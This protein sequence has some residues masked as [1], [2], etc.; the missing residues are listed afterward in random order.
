M[1]TRKYA[2]GKSVAA[3]PMIDWLDEIIVTA[4]RLDLEEVEAAAR[5]EQLAWMRV[6]GEANGFE[7]CLENLRAGITR[8][9]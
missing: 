1:Q 9:D 5:V 4:G 2:C 3:Q 7:V 8:R 6:R